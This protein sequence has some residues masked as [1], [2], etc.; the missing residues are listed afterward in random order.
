MKTAKFEPDLIMIY[1]DMGQ[2]RH[3][4]HVLSFIGNGLL[5]TPLYPVASCALAVVPVFL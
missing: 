5:E 2:S 1:S 3:M 4:P